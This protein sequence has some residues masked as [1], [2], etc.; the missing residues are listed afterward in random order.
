MKRVAVL[1]A[2]C[3]ARAAYADG[4]CRSVTVD[5]VPTDQLQIV[6]WVET[7]DGAYVDTAF[8]TQT[9]GRYGLGNRPGVMG[10][11]SNWHWPYGPRL[12]VFPVWAHR[13][14]HVFPW[15]AFQNG[16]GMPGDARDPD[17]QL[18]PVVSQLSAEPFY[19]KPMLPEDPEAITQS[20]T[21]GVFTDK[22][23]LIASLP[24][25]YP[26]RADLADHVTGDSSDVTQYAALDVFDAVSAAT[27]AGGAPFTIAWASPPELAAG[28]YRMF[29]EVALE[30]DFNATYTP[31]TYSVPPQDYS[32]YGSPYRGQ[33][34]VVYSLPFT[35]GT[36]ASTSMAATTD[37]AGYSDLDGV[38]HAPDATITTDT[39]GSGA[40]RLE[41]VADGSG[42]YR[43]RVTATQQTDL[44]P[45]A[46][47]G[48]LAATHVEA[49]S[50]EL[51][52]IAPGD[53]GVTGT[54]SGYDIRYVLGDDTLD[55]ASFAS[56]T[57]TMTA[58]APVAGGTRQ[59]VVLTG[60]MPD[61]RYTI[62][63]RA[64]DK[65][66]HV[67]PVAVVRLS[68]DTGD[69]ACGGCASGSSGLGG[70]FGVL[71]LVMRRRRR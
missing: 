42:M 11:K 69:A 9:T 25:L 43:M 16:D 31:D 28:D 30:N 61:E 6:A 21:S 66:G 58:P 24:S 68:T 34:S 38:L 53:D 63:V 20:C 4:V 71:L 62:G 14:G 47:P 26:P 50:A 60:L 64:Y 27:P 18:A 15:V 12:D 51:T 39:P 44:A 70:A 3:A 54:A 2:V 22:G 56:A 36:G 5:L 19:C 48:A 40:S 55:E 59:T 10:T 1:A 23:K 8:I 29:V 13:H 37:Y 41:L 46:E 67:G 17:N 52:F 35:I 45:P 33:P 65:C 32:N 57:H 49:T 7:A